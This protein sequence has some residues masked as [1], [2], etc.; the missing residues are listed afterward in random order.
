MFRGETVKILLIFIPFVIGLASS[1]SLKIGSGK[2]VKSGENLD[3]V[4]LNVVFQNQGQKC[5]GTLIAPQYVLTSATCVFDPV[6]GIATVINATF[7]QY[8]PTEFV[9]YKL[10]V[11]I[12][13]AYNST[14]HADDVAI[15]KLTTPMIPDAKFI[16]IARLGR[17]NTANVYVDNLVRACGMG[18][19]GNY[20]RP[21]RLLQ[22]TE[23]NVVPAESCNSNP[24]IICTQWPD[25]DNNMCNGDYGGP[26][27]SFTESIDGM[28]L[29]VIGIA[30]YSP[31]YRTG[32]SCLDAH[33]VS[34]AQVASYIDW[35]T[36]T[37]I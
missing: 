10:K 37:L 25:R 5:G 8:R 33:K 28:N 23:L 16:S 12:H 24:N 9:N 27:Y 30:Q 22:C 35:I 36:A 1:A 15:I 6:E 3:Y 31:D 13:P 26:I 20:P 17:N 21:P 11:Y 7:P 18:S 4:V 2:D 34:H 19:I 29:T 14:T 32:S